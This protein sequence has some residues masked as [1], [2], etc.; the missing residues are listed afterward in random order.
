LAL[1]K[2]EFKPPIYI[3]FT[4]GIIV[5]LEL[6]GHEEEIVMW[7]SNFETRAKVVASTSPPEPREERSPMGKLLRSSWLIPPDGGNA[8]VKRWLKMAQTEFDD[9]KWQLGGIPRKP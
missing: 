3:E 8:Q 6:G 5:S 7:V 1:L 2:F 4:P 9:P